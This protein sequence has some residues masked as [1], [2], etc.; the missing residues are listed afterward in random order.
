M[1]E[2]KYYDSKSRLA[3]DVHQGGCELADWARLYGKASF[4]R[5]PAGFL[6]F[7]PPDVLNVS[8]EYADTDPYSVETNIGGEFHT[9]RIDLTLNLLHE[10]VASAAG[11]LRVLDLGCGQGHITERMRQ[12]FDTAEFSALDFSVSAIEYAHTHFPEIDFIVADACDCPYSD[13]YFD[14]VVCNNLWE[15]VPDPLRLLAGIRRILKPGGHVIISTPSRYRTSNLIRV[16]RGKPVVFMSPYHVTEYSVGQ[17]KEQLA[18]GGFNVRS[19]VTRP[20]SAG[21]LKARLARS[22]FETVVSLTSSHH[23]LESTV[24]Y[25]AQKPSAKVR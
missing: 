2:A 22:L 8:N 1:S 4:A 3:L 24:F 14:A 7:L 9:R 25:V 12:A 20:I 19:V 23:Q 17:V 21:S 18:Y 10:A 15:H 5:H 11:K 6:V 13:A 16:L